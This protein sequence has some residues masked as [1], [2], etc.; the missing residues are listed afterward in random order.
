MKDI[1]HNHQLQVRR[2]STFSFEEYLAQKYLLP[3]LARKLVSC[4]TWD[5]IL[6]RK[7]QI[8]YAA[9]RKPENL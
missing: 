8:L 3:G 7:P 9:Y 1:S 4:L 2:Q 6:T 5:L